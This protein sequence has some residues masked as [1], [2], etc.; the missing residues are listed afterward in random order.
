[1]RRRWSSWQWVYSGAADRVSSRNGAGER[2]RIEHLTLEEL[3]IRWLNVWEL[4]GE[5][6]QTPRR[7]PEHGEPGRYPLELR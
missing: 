6:E 7:D 1:M 2:G 5:Q 3:G 4:I